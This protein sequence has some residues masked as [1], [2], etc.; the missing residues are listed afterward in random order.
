[1]EAARFFTM[2]KHEGEA[3]V[4]LLKAHGKTP[5]DLWRAAGKTPSA[6]T[7]WVQADEFGP[8]AW[9]TVRD[10]LLGMG[11]PTDSIRP[12]AIVMA[13]ERT[14]RDLTP[15]VAEWSKEQLR[16]LRDLLQASDLERTQLAFWIRGKLG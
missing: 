10:A 1:M 4:A 8:G 9:R 14:A 16:T 2:A 7:K 15:L 13:R 5:A 11:I 6:E 12:D 3:L